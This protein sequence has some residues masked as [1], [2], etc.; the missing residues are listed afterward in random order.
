MIPDVLK[1]WV[2][3]PGDLPRRVGEPFYIDPRGPEVAGWLP[4]PTDNCELELVHDTDANGR[5]F[6]RFSSL[7][8][9]WNEDLL[10]VMN[11]VAFY[12]NNSIQATRLV[13]AP[14]FEAAQNFDG[15]QIIRWDIVKGPNWA[16]ENIVLEELLWEDPATGRRILSVYGWPPYDDPQ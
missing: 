7:T 3:N 2:K 8:G 12:P 11:S 9:H 6:A 1:G 16:R 5:P 15:W 4:T 10:A 13:G 14:G